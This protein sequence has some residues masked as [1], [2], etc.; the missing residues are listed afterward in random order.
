MSKTAI[1]S[2]L[3]D[4][5]KRMREVK[6]GLRPQGNAAGQKWAR[7][8]AHPAQLRLLATTVSIYPG[9][10][11]DLL[12]DW[13]KYLE[14]TADWSAAEKLCELLVNY[15]L[16]E[17]VDHDPLSVTFWRR[18]LGEGLC[19][20]VTEPDFLQGFI[21]GALTT[22]EQVLEQAPELDKPSCR[23][24]G[25]ASPMTTQN[26]VVDF[27]EKIGEPIDEDTVHTIMNII[28]G[29]R[30]GRRRGTGGGL[31]RPSDAEVH[32]QWPGRGDC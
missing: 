9:S 1:N 8:D 2:N 31:P 25:A 20:W 11:K 13:S 4:V 26:A 22:W 30:T 29:W 16:P 32:G 15:T 6:K 28:D 12:N 24:G 23:S 10:I 19:Q 5:I 27:L 21:E 17:R 18:V 7:C 14:I 3:D